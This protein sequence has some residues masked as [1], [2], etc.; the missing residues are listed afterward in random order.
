MIAEQTTKDNQRR[1]QESMKDVRK[2]KFNEALKEWDAFKERVQS[3]LADGRITEDE[4]RALLESK[5]DELDL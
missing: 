3:L 5:A 2:K 4:R 1:N